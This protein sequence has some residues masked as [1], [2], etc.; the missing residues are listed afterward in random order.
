MTNE[1]E[2]SVIEKRRLSLIAG[3]LF[4]FLDN[5]IYALQISSPSEGTIVHQGDQVQVVAVP[6]QGE[7]IESVFFAIPHVDSMI[8]FQPPFEFVFTVPN[9]V[10]GQVKI[11]ADG[12]KQGGGFS[13]ASVN[14]TVAF[15]PSI[16][17][18][19]LRVNRDQ[20][21]LLMSI[22]DKEKIYLY[23]QFSDGVKRDI[24]S[25]ATGTTYQTSDARIATVDAEGLVTAV[26][27]GKAVI[28][29]KN[30]SKQIRIEVQI[31]AR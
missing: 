14:I 4:Y 9:E 20:E 23:G 19:G 12:K 30:G 18:Q 11:F 15:P 2:D 28:I 16:V 17:L 6:S 13:K 7:Q 1:L 21:I 31:T 8:D 26:A 5:P 27:P 25:S 10:F 22:E 24:S 3:L 29:A